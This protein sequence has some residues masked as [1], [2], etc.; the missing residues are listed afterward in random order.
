VPKAEATATPAPEATPEAADHIP[1]G[2]GT[3]QGTG[4]GSGE[5]VDVIAGGLNPADIKGRHTLAEIAEGTGVPLAA[6]LAALKLDPNTD[7]DTQVRKLVEGGTLDE[8][9]AVRTV[10]AE[11]QAAP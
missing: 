3:G 6:L 1:A 8:I 4:D 2:D 5:G 10:V 11:L 7:P 9:E